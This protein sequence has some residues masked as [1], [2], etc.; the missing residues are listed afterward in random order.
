MVICDNF[1]LE[2]GKIRY[3]SKG[4]SGGNNGLKSIDK[5][6]GSTEYARLR[7]GTG[8]PE[9][10]AKVEAKDFVLSKFSIEEKR[11]LQDILLEVSQKIDEFI[12]E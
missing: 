2:F 7:V 1:D 10:Q 6:L 5:E 12:A 9:V 11:Q 8:N 3:R 4:S